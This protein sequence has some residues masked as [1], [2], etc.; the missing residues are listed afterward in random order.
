[1]RQDQTGGKSR[2]DTGC[3][4]HRS[5]A[6]NLQGKEGQPEKHAL[7]GVDLTIPRGSVFGLLGPNGAGKSTMINILAG[8]V[9][10]TSG[11]VTIWG[12]DQDANP[13]Q[14]RAA[15]GVMPQELNLDPFF[16]PRGALEVQAGLYGVPKSERRKR[17]DPGNGGSDGQ[18][19][20]LCADPVGRGCGG[21]CC[22]ARR[23]CTI[24]MCL[25]WMNPPQASTSNCARCCGKTCAS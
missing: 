1:M 20:C 19:P 22:W 7:K 18:G 21:G 24:P 11:R 5:A 17:R 2:N 8:L 3:N 9:R 16:T 15:I 6:Q 4:P 13:R 23:W 12:F 10:K 25:C 14:S